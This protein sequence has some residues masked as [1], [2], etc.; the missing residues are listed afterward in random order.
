MTVAQR[1][2]RPPAPAGDSAFWS[3][4]ILTGASAVNRQS[5]AASL[6]RQYE[7][8][9]PDAT[10]AEYEAAMRRIARICRV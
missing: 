7:S 1:R 10:P 5:A 3:L 6:K 8:T 9:F 2:Y 4:A